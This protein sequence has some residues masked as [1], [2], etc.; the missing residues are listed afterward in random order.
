MKKFDYRLA[1][2]RIKLLCEIVS[3]VFTSLELVEEVIKL[4]GMAFNYLTDSNDNLP[5]MGT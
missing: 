1:Q 3:L 2:E 5:K 4:L